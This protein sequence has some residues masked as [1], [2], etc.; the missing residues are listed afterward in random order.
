MTP[1]PCD[2]ESHEALASTKSDP[3]LSSSKWHDVSDQIDRLEQRQSDLRRAL[4]EELLCRLERIERN[5]AELNDMVLGMKAEPPENGRLPTAKGLALGSP[6]ESVE[7]SHRTHHARPDMGLPPF[8]RSFPTLPLLPDPTSRAIPDVEP[9]GSLGDEE[10]PMQ[11]SS[12]ASAEPA[13]ANEHSSM[14]LP[15]PT[16][17]A[18]PDVEPPGSPG[19]F[20]FLWQ[21]LTA[22]KEPPSSRFWKEEVRIQESSA[23]SAEPAP[24]SEHSSMTLP[25]P[26]SRA[27][28][29]VEPPGSPGD[30][31]VPMQESSAAAAE[32]T[33]SE[34]SG[35]AVPLPEDFKLPKA[36]RR[37]LFRR[38]RYEFDCVAPDFLWIP[39]RPTG[40]ERAAPPTPPGFIST[41]VTIPSTRAP[42]APSARRRA[43]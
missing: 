9:P 28:P 10:V 29:D 43:D 7:P 33:D 36:R 6:I 12:A 18:I 23:A 32:P 40:A 17:R 21:L 37:W 26:T 1:E 34:P 39:S 13:P 19:D 20:E 30:E 42:G 15:D 8:A 31:E 16:S 3:T 4:W 35:M 27:I 11:E 24:A 25:D 5:Q 38:R 22:P 14:T 2:T 41:E